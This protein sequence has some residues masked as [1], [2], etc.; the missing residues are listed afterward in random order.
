MDVFS[1]IVVGYH[2]CEEEFARDLLLDNLRIPDWKPSRNAWD[3]LGHGIYF[4]EYSPARALRWA[5]ERYETKGKKAAVIGALIHLG[6]CFD[7]LDE[8]LMDV[9]VETYHRLEKSLTESG[10]A[11]PINT[12]QDWKKRER[13]CLVLNHFLGTS[14]KNGLVFDTVR[15]AFLEGEPA[16]AGAGFSRESH[17]QIA[18][19]TTSCILGV[20]RP[21]MES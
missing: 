3:W 1:R 6:R 2:G 18:V 15:G 13:D 8:S 9:L 7:L 14:A 4:W 20:F 10:L 19:R 5:R 16:Y 17:L 21:N 11:M 12:G